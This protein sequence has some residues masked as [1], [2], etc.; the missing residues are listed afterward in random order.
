MDGIE[1]GL[2]WLAFVF[3][4]ADAYAL[5]RFH[6]A[7]RMGEDA[8][9]A[10]RR[11]LSSALRVAGA[12]VAGFVLFV[13]LAVVAVI[14]FILEWARSGG[15]GSPGWPASFLLLLGGCVVLVGLPVGVAIAQRRRR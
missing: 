6:S 4:C 10:G 13:G 7:R 14:V 11:A 3:V 1:Y 9:T 8:A 15:S 2:A 5:W 12:G